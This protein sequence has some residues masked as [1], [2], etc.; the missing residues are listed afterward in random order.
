MELLRFQWWYLRVLTTCQRCLGKVGG[1]IG[2]FPIGSNVHG[3]LALWP[4]DL[5]V[6]S[7]QRVMNMLCNSPPYLTLM[8]TVTAF[9]DDDVDGVIA[10]SLEPVVAD[11]HLFVIIMEGV[12]HS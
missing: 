3:M 6:H 4:H 11:T 9:E 1:L 7:V 2:L 12:G 10:D 5:R 8:Q